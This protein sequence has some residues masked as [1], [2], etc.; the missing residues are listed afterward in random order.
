MHGLQNNEMG[1]H[2]LPGLRASSLGYALYASPVMM[3]VMTC[4]IPLSHPPVCNIDCM[5]KVFPSVA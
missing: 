3:E 5:R 2:Y 1:T 4:N